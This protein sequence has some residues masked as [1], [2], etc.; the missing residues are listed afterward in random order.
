MQG[1]QSKPA[2]A[3]KRLVRSDAAPSE[4]QRETE[5]LNY[6]S[7]AKRVL[8]EPSR[9]KAIQLLDRERREYL[10]HHPIPAKLHGRET[11]NK[12]GRPPAISGQSLAIFL[13]QEGRG[14][15]GR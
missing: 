1:R 6:Y 8:T 11:P 10:K 14:H 7:F 13:V 5:A 9:T 4:E 2:R 15:D 3:N 12:R